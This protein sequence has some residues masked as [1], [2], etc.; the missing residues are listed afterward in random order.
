MANIGHQENNRLLRWLTSA[1]KRVIH[2]LNG[3]YWSL[4]ECI[5]LLA[6]NIGHQVRWV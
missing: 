1:L 3:R 6:A 4:R 2:P 5:T